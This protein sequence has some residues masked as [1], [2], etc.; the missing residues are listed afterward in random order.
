MTNQI[1]VAKWWAVKHNVALINNEF[2][3]NPARAKPEHLLAYFETV[4][5]IFEELEIPWQVWFG[6][7]DNDKELLEG[8]D[9]A[10]GLKK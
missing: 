9:K 10:L 6:P 5:S 7:F 1:L 3:A 4:C 8:M 2:G